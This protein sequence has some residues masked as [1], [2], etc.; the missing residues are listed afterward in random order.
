MARSMRRAAARAACLL[1]LLRGAAAGIV[2]TD[3]SELCTTNLGA[4][5]QQCANAGQ[6]AFQCD[7]G[8]TFSRPSSTCRCVK[9]PP[10]NPPFQSERRAAGARTSTCLGRMRAW[11]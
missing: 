5:Q 6:F 7:E 2:Q 10:G 8:G 1:V 4:C 9:V 3:N 11:R